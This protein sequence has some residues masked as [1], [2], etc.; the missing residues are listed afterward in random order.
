M[1][2]SRPP[3]S[4]HPPHPAIDFADFF[5]SKVGKIPAETANSP[6]PVIIERHCERLSAFDDLTA[7][8]IMRPDGKWKDVLETVINSR[9][10]TDAQAN[11]STQR[12]RYLSP[13]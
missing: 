1:Y 5:Q 10:L 13:I 2:Y 9:K 8:E 6:S 11:P 3:N 4:L 7:D 12:K